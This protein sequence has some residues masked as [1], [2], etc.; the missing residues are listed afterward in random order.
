MMGDTQLGADTP[1]TSMWFPGR[2]QGESG[3]VVQPSGE[4]GG[5]AA[6]VGKQGGSQPSAQ[7]L[8]SYRKPGLRWRHDPGVSESC[9]PAPQEAGL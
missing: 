2:F 5:P 6:Q 3:E 1:P 4:P 7:H 8:T 9:L